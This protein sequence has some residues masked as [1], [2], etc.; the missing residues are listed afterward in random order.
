MLV[1]VAALG[2]LLS[3][4]SPCVW[5]LYPVYVAQVATA[6]GRRP[7]AGAALF[8]LGFTAVFVALGATASALGRFLQAYQLPFEKVSGVLIVV[9]GLALAG[10]L[11][12]S[13]L[14]NPHPVGWRPRGGGPA[15][16]V[17]LGM[18]FAFGWTPCVGP[19]LAS[20]LVLAGD[21]RRLG[22]GIG[23]LLAYSAGFA[24]PFLGLAAMVARG[25]RL[26]GGLGPWLPR[27]QRVGGVLL[28]GLGVLVFTG[29]LAEIA[30]Y[31]YGRI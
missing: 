21:A 15:A 2:G 23:L 20:I 17:L 14:G 10:L 9:L 19:V 22:P 5:P 4:F 27:L 18:A 11:P 29:S 16:A 28:A 7:A 25:P 24:L 31:L 30:T 12:E 6:G 3:F 13:W 8:S 1:F 26:L